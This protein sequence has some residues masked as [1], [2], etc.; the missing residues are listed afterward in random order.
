MLR[1]KLATDPRWVEVVLQDIGSFLIDHAYCERKASGTA[2]KLLS[3]Y[4]DRKELVEAMIPLAQE[5]LEHF[6]LVYRQISA[7]GLTLTQDSSDLYVKKL[8]KTARGQSDDYFLDRLLLSSLIEGRSPRLDPRRSQ[9]SWALYSSGQDLFS[10]RSGRGQARRATRKRSRD[11]SIAPAAGRR[12][13]KPKGRIY[14]FTNFLAGSR[15]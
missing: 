6:A 5:E 1:L 3:H 7:L 13:L 14:S 11:C 15:L 4:P 8:L 2:L 10:L 9:A 12:P